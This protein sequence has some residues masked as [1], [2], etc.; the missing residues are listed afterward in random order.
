MT[1]TEFISEYRTNLVC[2]GYVLAVWGVV[3][4][5]ITLTNKH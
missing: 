5:A 4:L 1:L 3:A 2:V